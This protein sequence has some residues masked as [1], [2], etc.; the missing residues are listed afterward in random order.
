[1]CLSE[2]VRVQ[3]SVL[4][5]LRFKL[6]SDYPGAALQCRARTQ[7]LGQNSDANRRC[8]FFGAQPATLKAAPVG[9]IAWLGERRGRQARLS[10]I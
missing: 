5:S 9:S 10:S 2:S 1:M 6:H 3:L 7:W 8:R 4:S